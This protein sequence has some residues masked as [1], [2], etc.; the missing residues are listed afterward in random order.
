MTV[1]TSKITAGP[2]I[3]NNIADTF[4]Y[5][6]RIKD[7]DQLSVY[8]TTDDGV[9]TLLVVDTDYTVNGVG[10]D[11]GGTI[12][13]TAG[14]LPTDYTLYIRADYKKTQLTAF[15]S[16]GA[17][18]PDLHEDAMDQLTFLVQQSCD[19]IDRSPRLP[20]S[21][22]GK[23][24]LSLPTPEAGKLIYWN[25]DEDGFVNGGAPG[26]V[27]PENVETTVVGMIANMSLQVG[28]SVKTQ[29]YYTPGDNGHGD[30][31]ISSTGTNDGVNHLL[32][33]GKFAILQNRHGI[34]KAEQAGIIGDWDGS[35]GTDETT[36][37]QAAIDWFSNKTGE[38]D[39]SSLNIRA[40]SARI[41]FK[42]VS[43]KGSKAPSA[44]YTSGAS[45]YCGSVGGLYT[46]LETNTAPELANFK[47]FSA[48]ERTQNGQTVV[49]LTGL[50]YPRM[51]NVLIYGGENGLKLQDG[52]SVESHYG[53]FYSVDISRSYNGVMVLGGN[54]TQTH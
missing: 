16:Q 24:P 14:A 10:V 6:F 7:K 20:D 11:Q 25:L 37:L 21:Y 43:I 38:L 23:L 53:N 44:G 35:N 3:G 17:F 31:I 40:D 26:V 33:N 30:Y 50:N 12:I 52:A 8:E 39:I 45:I 1:N 49:D 27:I 48:D 46:S 36:R 5:G 41:D 19:S 18:F 28:Q 32:A 2:Y 15:Q 51:N 54:R 22:S 42:F 9:E 47:V 4:S 13:L 34:L 29:V